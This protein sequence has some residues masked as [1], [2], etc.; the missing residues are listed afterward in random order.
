MN[1]F[2]TL[3]E[4]QPEPFAGREA[5]YARLQQQIVDPPD[6][7]AL[8]YIGHDGMGKTALLRH[9]STVFDD[10]L[11]SI[12]VSLQEMNLADEDVWL[13][14]LITEINQ[15]LESLNFSLSRVPELDNENEETLKDWIR[16]T[17]LTEVL[18][19]LRPHRHLVFLLDDAEHLLNAPEGHLAYLYE[20]LEHHSQLA[21]VLT[22]NTKYEDKLNELIPLVNPNNAE[23]IHRLTAEDCADVIR[24]YAPGADDSI[25][26]QIFEATGGHARLLARYGR[27]L[28]K[29]WSQETDSQ[30][31]ESAQKA[32]YD[33]SLEEFR[34]IW[35]DLSRNERLVLTAI[36]SLIYDDPL[37][38]VTPKLIEG[39]LIETDYPMDIVG[40]G[41]ALRSLDYHDIVMQLPNQGLQL[42]MG[43]MQKWLLEHAR[44]DDE[45]SSNRGTIPVRLIL[46]VIAVIIVLILAVVLLPNPIFT[47]DNVSATA[48]LAN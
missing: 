27:E 8:I 34:L 20:L 18:H 44:L 6:R 46:I 37:R 4:E 41:A 31:F 39:W 21:I 48:T 23:R 42:V 11:L 1:E 33:S 32:V 24:Q 15:L 38:Q 29:H 26:E 47:G 14:Y 22:L 16:D 40:I 28:Q 25:V 7:H 35:L 10:P 17:Y 43:L 9:F 36:A 45:T 5:V 19:I 2:D 30:A 3:P 12:F 13:Q